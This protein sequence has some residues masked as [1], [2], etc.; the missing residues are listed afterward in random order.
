[1]RFIAVVQSHDVVHVILVL[2]LVALTIV[3]VSPLLLPRIQ[4][5]PLSIRQPVP[6]YGLEYFSEVKSALLRSSGWLTAGWPNLAVN[7]SMASL[8]H[9]SV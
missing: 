7:L 9:D 5:L 1:M 2:H 4:E 3:V 8:L 6:P